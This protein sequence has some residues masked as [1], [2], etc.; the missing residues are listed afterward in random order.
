[1]FLTKSTGTF[2]N[3]V[4]AHAD[5]FGKFFSKSKTKNLDNNLKICSPDILITVLFSETSVTLA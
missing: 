5:S 2:T 1:L 4:C 3:N